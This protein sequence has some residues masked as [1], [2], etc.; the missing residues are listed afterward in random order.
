MHIIQNDKLL[1][2]LNNHLP[3]ILQ[4][5][6]RCQD[7]LQW[8]LY[9]MK[10]AFSCEAALKICIVEIKLETTE[11]KA[12]V[13]VL[14]TIPAFLLPAEQALDWIFMKSGSAVSLNHE[15]SLCAQQLHK[16]A[17]SFSR[18]DARP[19][20]SRYCETTGKNLKIYRLKELRK[21]WMNKLPRQTRPSHMH[22]LQTH[23][24]LC[25]FDQQ[26]EFNKILQRTRIRLHETTKNLLRNIRQQQS[27]KNS[28]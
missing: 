22:W 26:S 28:Q 1:I 11:N 3:K 6:T 15:P 12:K 23:K 2:I 4:L 27:L 14:T 21:N 5:T 17:F 25:I 18:S 9:L 7:F 10:F 16:T 24:T 8:T 19:D 13:Q 20:Q